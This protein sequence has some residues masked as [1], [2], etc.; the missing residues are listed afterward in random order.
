MK[1]GYFFVRQLT[2]KKPY[3]HAYHHLLVWLNLWRH[4][5]SAKHGTQTPD[6]YPVSLR[7]PFNLLK[8]VESARW[9]SRK[10]SSEQ[11]RKTTNEPGRS[12]L[13]MWPPATCWQRPGQRRNRRSSDRRSQ[14]EGQRTWNWSPDSPLW[15]RRHR[16]TE[17]C[18]SVWNLSPLD[19][20]H[21]AAVEDEEK[22]D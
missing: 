3:F 20:P 11:L 16:H 2:D 12:A 21:R 4:W 17:F 9:I 8:P 22:W 1:S 18:S 19:T 13:Q 14:G 5:W 10:G 7:F 6:Q 15:R